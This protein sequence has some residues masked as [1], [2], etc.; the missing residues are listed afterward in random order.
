M[1][2]PTTSA[3]PLPSPPVDIKPSTPE[4]STSSIV[5]QAAASDLGKMNIDTFAQK[6]KAKYPQYASLDNTEL[7]NKI[8]AKYPQYKEQIDFGTP[9]TSTVSTITPEVAKQETGI[10][11]SSEGLIP[12]SVRF[13]S[14]DNPFSS[15]EIR[16]S[17]NL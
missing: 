6:I 17:S 4:T 8:V 13:G 3:Q 11:N 15:E 14:L 1:I 5:T 7:T 10:F 12:E 16:A 9:S 2:P